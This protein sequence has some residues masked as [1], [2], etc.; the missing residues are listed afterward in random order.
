MCEFT[1][2]ATES[3][4]RTFAGWECV[5]CK[6]CKH[7]GMGEACAHRHGITNAEEMDGNWNFCMLKSVCVCTYVCGSGGDGCGGWCWCW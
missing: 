1:T 7:V 6:P 5:S 4:T 3:H 2:R